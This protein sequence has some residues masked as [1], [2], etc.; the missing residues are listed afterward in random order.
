MP[1]QLHKLDSTTMK[2]NHASLSENRL[3]NTAGARTDLAGTAVAE[4]SGALRPLLADVFALYLKTKNFHWH[5]S[6]S[7][8][9]DYHLLLDEHADQIFAMT[10]DIAER[11]RKIGGTKKPSLRAC[12]EDRS[13]R[14]CEGGWAVTICTGKRKTEL[15]PTNFEQRDPLDKTPVIS[16]T[17]AIQ[18]GHRQ[19]FPPPAA[20]GKAPGSGGR[21]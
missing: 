9:R 11:A 21:G 17:A 1:S 13:G 8:F 14:D 12:F 5:M 7:H 19:G 6:G 4:I 20:P 15:R 2:T 16:G 10:D 3:R 18:P